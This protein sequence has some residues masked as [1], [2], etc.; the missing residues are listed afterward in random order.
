MTEEAKVET[1]IT[2]EEK[3]DNGTMDNEALQQM[4]STMISLSALLNEKKGDVK[5]VNNVYKQMAEKVKRH[6]VAN[7]L[8]YVDLEGH[9]VHTYSRVRE[10]PMNSDFISDGLTDFFTDTK[11]KS[12]T[13]PRHIAAQAAAYLVA[14]KKDKIDG[15]ETWTTTLRNISKKRMKAKQQRE[16]ERLVDDEGLAVGVTDVVAVDDAG[17]QP[18]KRQR[19]RRDVKSA[20]A[21]L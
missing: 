21:L 2:G 12:F 7:K 8:K 14:R 20:R 19:R 1:T 11:I 13:N 10:S 4:I 17:S 9:Q 5:K 15:K 6:M 3:D 18:A 16:N